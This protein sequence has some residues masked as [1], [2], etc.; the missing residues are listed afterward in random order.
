MAKAPNPNLT[1][2][3]EQKLRLVSMMIGPL[4]DSLAQFSTEAALT[5]DDFIDTLSMALGM[6]LANDTNLKTPRDVREG[7]AVIAKYIE[8][9]ADTF[10]KA[11]EVVGGESAFMKIL[12]AYRANPDEPPE[13]V[14]PTVN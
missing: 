7:A 3:P 8:R 2:A 5:A 9:H 4:S 13:I 6:L 11:Q 10:R 14:F 12:N 1:V